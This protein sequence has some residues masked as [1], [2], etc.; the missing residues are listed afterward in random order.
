M[1]T[2]ETFESQQNRDTAV[3][4]TR[5][6]KQLLRL[7]GEI[8]D[9]SVEN[10]FA[11]RLRAHLG[12][13]PSTLPVTNQS[14]PPY[15]LVD[16]HI[17]FE[18][19]PEEAPGRS[20]E[21]IGIAGQHTH[22]QSF[23]D[24]VTPHQR[25]SVG[26]VEY[27][28]VADSPSTTRNCL[29]FATIL[30]RENDTTWAVM[31]R[32]P[33]ENQRAGCSI[34]ITTANPGDAKRLLA[35]IRTLAVDHSVLRGQIVA[36]GP[37]EG[38]NY[39]GLRFMARPELDRG[40]LIL[41]DE[42]I[43]RIEGH[44]VGV[45]HHHERLVAAR[46]HLK[47]GVLLYGP[48]GTGKT[49]T[50]RYLLSQLTDRTAFILSGQ[51][52]GMISQACALA[53]L[54]SPSIVILE[55]IDLIAGDRSFSP[56]GSNALLFE[57]LNQIDGL[58]G[59][60]DVTFLLTTNRVDIL[61]KALSERPGRVDVAVEI[62][63][64]NAEGRRRLLDLYGS[65]LGVADLSTEDVASTIDATEG[66]TATFMREVVRRAALIAAAETE[67]G[68][69]QVDGHIL[70]RATQSLTEDRTQLTRSILNGSSEPDAEPHLA[71]S[72]GMVEGSGWVGARSGY[73]RASPRDDSMPFGSSD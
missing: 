67:I 21:V 36:L 35:D 1:S 23:R 28:D 68:E 70:E 5:T 42:D 73:F 4:F 69:L 65:A 51:S 15:Q 26:P 71:M 60:V 17:A 37:G 27:T 6:L 40:D 39:G 31:F 53:K 12:D 10:E 52:L 9:F 34:E 33:E 62:A 44:V 61:E 72:P 55:D 24:L 41:P 59:D 16:M 7:I 25:Y 29:A 64:P 58:D 49:H 3:E 13:D 50:V 32:G 43:S 63:P 20:M 11:M 22:H 66:R 57:V 8:P 47:R 54:L 48:P 38:N 30:L 46:Q 45:A 56:V 14:F 19:W 18:L 2:D